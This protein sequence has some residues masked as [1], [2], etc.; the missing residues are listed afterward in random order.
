MIDNSKNVFARTAVRVMRSVAMKAAQN[1]TGRCVSF[2]YQ[3][4]VP[5][6]MAE[7]LQVMRSNKK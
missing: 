3:P 7:R 5:K 6:N 4:S 2:V 1:S